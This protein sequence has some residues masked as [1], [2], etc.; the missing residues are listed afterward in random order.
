MQFKG[1]IEC[2]SLTESLSI[3]YGYFK[4]DIRYGSKWNNAQRFS[5]GVHIFANFQIKKSKSP[6]YIGDLLFVTFDVTHLRLVEAMRDSLILRTFN[7][8]KFGHG[9]FSAFFEVQDNSSIIYVYFIFARIPELFYSRKNIHSMLV[10]RYI[11]FSSE[12]LNKTNIF[13]LYCLHLSLPTHILYHIS[14]YNSSHLL[15]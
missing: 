9:Y 6:L 10:E 4:P 7:I 11:L 1:T 13:T 3:K 14:Q 15:F 5:I 2:G 8:C 12:F